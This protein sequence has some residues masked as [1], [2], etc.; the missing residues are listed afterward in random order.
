MDLITQRS[1]ETVYTFNTF[2]YSALSNKGYEHVC[3]WTKKVDIF[4]K[5]KIFIPVHLEEE[6]HWCLVYIDFLK[7]TIKYYD[8]LGGRNFSC[9]KQILRYLMLEHVNKKHVDF[10]PGGWC[11]VNDRDCPKQ[12]NIWDCGVFVC[13]YAEYLSRNKPLNFSQKDMGRFRKQ[14]YREIK[15]KKLFKEC[16]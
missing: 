14:I 4:S 12:L 9:L 5:E 8:S 2:F 1:P 15:Q 13:M 10:R 6:N 16:E 3:R 7:K 11:L